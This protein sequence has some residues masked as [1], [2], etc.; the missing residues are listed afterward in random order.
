MT[1]LYLFCFLSFL[2]FALSIQMKN[3]SHQVFQQ[4]NKAG[5]YPELDAFLNGLKPDMDRISQ[6]RRSE[7]DSLSGWLREEEKKGG[8]IRLVFICTHNSRRSHFGQV[9][10]AVAARKFGW[11][12]VETFS[13]G[14]EATACNPRSVAAFQRAGL[15]VENP[16]GENPRY[17]VKM[18]EELPPLVCFSKKF[19]D[20]FNPQS[21]FA[22]VMTCTQADRAC[23]IVPGASYRISI[24][25]EDPKVSDGTPQEAATYDARCRQ[26][27]A[28]MMYV[29]SRK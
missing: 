23:P 19:S 5:F 11:K 1:T 14:T 27:A 4:T 24:P 15:K 29:F 22:A 3:T 17:L 8:P 7:L 12:N 16:G 6:E 20:P 28:E 18:G 13:G 10:S 9:W 25:Y 21:A 2:Q 26:I